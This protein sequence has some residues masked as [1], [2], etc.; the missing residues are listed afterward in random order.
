MS[1]FLVSLSSDGFIHRSALPEPPSLTFNVLGDKESEKL[2]ISF[3]P[4][5]QA[6]PEAITIP[7]LASFMN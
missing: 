2:T 7:A 6:M 1:S 5:G 4:L 3:E